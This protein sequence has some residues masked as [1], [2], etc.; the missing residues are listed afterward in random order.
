MHLVLRKFSIT[1][2]VRIKFEMI[3]FQMQ[4]QLNSHFESKVFFYLSRD[5]KSSSY[6]IALSIPDQLYHSKKKRYAH[7]IFSQDTKVSGKDAFGC[8]IR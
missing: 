4:L 3:L 6:S 8:C 1:S 7:F 2:P 5:L